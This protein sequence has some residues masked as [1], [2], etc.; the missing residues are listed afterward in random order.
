MFV[1]VDCDLR[2]WSLRR[3]GGKLALSP[4][5]SLL[6]GAARAEP[7]ATPTVAAPSPAP[8]RLSRKSVQLQGRRR[9]GSY[10]PFGP[11]LPSPRPL[12]EV[13][14][15]LAPAAI[16][17][18][19]MVGSTSRAAGSASRVAGSAPSATVP[20]LPQLRRGRAPHCAAE[21]AP[22]AEARHGAVVA[23]PVGG[24]QRGVLVAA[25]AAARATGA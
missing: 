23:A 6:S 22:T 11:L 13:A 1:E 25:A 19:G 5:A 4:P 9:W 2:V 3:G 24:T 17:G 21:A 14:L 15:S 16:P 8:S 7:D 10:F 18:S 12:L 20:V